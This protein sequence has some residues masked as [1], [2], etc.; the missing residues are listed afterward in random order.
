MS[1]PAKPVYARSGGRNERN[2]M[3][4]QTGPQD[5][6]SLREHAVLNFMCALIMANGPSNAN[7]DANKEK[8]I[9]AQAGKF[10]TAYLEELGGT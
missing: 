9:A 10:A 6:I 1:D 5:G 3:I 4:T 8:T 7:K 2:N